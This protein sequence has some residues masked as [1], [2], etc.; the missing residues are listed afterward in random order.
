MLRLVA[1]LLLMMGI[2]DVWGQVDGIYYI[3]NYHDKDPHYS[4]ETVNTNYY[5]VPA[6]DG[7]EANIDINRWAWKDDAATPFVT[8][9]KTKRDNN[10][11]WVIKESD[12][13]G[14]YYLIH[15]LTGKYMTL[16]DGV[17]TNS[18]RRTFHMEETSNLGNDHLFNFTSYSDALT[19]YSIK[20]KTLSSG[21]R[22]VN[23]SKANQDKYYGT[24]TEEGG[25]YVAGLIGLYNKNATQDSGSKWFLE[26]ASVLP[27][28]TISDVN[29]TN[30]KV[31][32]TENNS[33]PTGYKVHYTFSAEGEPEDP[34][35][36]S[37]EMTNG[38]YQVTVAG[39]LKVVVERYDIVL[40]EV[41][42]KY[43]E[44]YSCANPVI[45]YS[46]ETGKVTIT[47][48][49]D[50]ASI[51]YTLDGT[52]PSASSTL[53]G[54][55]FSVADETTI[56]AIATKSGFADS[57]KASS[58]LLLN[59]TITLATTEYSYS[60]S[61]IEPAVSSVQDGGKTIGTDEYDVGYEYNT[62]AGTATVNITDK[63][64]G[65]YII[66]GSATFTI[67]PKALVITA[68]AKSKAYGDADPALTYTSEGLV[69]SD[70]ITGALN[71][72]VGEN[73][74]TYA[75][76]QNTL[77]AG[78]NY[79]ISYTGANLT[80]TPKA[81]TVTAKSKT[82]TYGDEPANDGVTYS[83]FVG[84][85]NASNL[86]GTITYAC[87]YEKYGDVGNY[88]ITPSGLTS[89]NYD[90][91][92]NNG[93]LI[94]NPKE[95]SLTW[96]ETTS[97]PY[98]GT[99]HCPTATATGMVNGDEIGVT[100]KGG[101][102]NA[103]NHTATAS[104]LMGDKANNYK[105]PDANTREFSI[106]KVGLTVT[107]NDN[108]ITYGNAPVGNGVTCEGFVNSETASVLGGTLDYDYSYTQYSDVGNTYTITPK[109]LTSNNYDI[110]FVAGTLTVAQKEV[111]ITW[112][113]TTSFVY[114]GSAHAPTATATGLVNSDAVTVVVTG[115]QINVGGYTATVSS[116]TGDKAGNYILL[117]ANTQSFTISPKSIG[118]GTLAEGY[119]LDFGE[120]NTIL[121]KDDIIGNA[122]MVSAD[123]SV[124]DDRDASAK[125]SERT[126]TG[127]GNYTGSFDVR[128]VVVSLTTDTDQEEWSATFA[129]EKADESDIGHALPEGISAFIISGIQGE[130][131]IPEPLNYIPE[132]VPV[133]LV[134]HKQINGF[135]VTRAESGDV[136]P[137]PITD[138][139]KTKNM[140][141]EVTE[142]TPGYDSGSESV[143]FETKQIYVL[144]KNEFVFNKAG[145]MKIGKVYLNPNHTAP[146]PGSAPARLKIA[147]NH[148]TGIQIIKDES[149][150][151]MQDDIWYTIDG[152]RLSGKPNAKGLYI[153]DGK[154]IVIK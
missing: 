14:D 148:T 68:E 78:S 51:Y 128:N 40:T 87:N 83:G 135:V 96:S 94:V 21:H 133:L 139:Q 29:Q 71:R 99:C 74:G 54:E 153:V 44:P 143:H 19:Y 30:N 39:T 82:I 118:E 114:D 144:Y 33:L 75:I 104:S 5:L 47:S 46:T 37:A 11:V 136:I 152:R 146:S 34:T 88:T 57:E 95:V 151:K 100:V 60:G 49:T 72:E 42:T 132:G 85:E 56:Q 18:N 112:G 91:T 110:S 76:N 122:L 7:G 129:A 79:S 131:V 55:P 109:G 65:N 26:T 134:A 92:Y 154:K 90:I 80:I 31:T 43:V 149:V 62:D 117:D 25:F 140:L 50:G 52:T 98:D 22:F 106:T 64:G 63:E 150:V 77:T 17:G 108:T 137:I 125:Y 38:E 66:Y 24:G 107:A 126:V 145:N 32:I 89:N 10:S 16:N 58:K 142:D 121:L 69:G 13:T 70:A 127:I 138:V 120:G 36:T 147:W 111:G 53:Y 4:P 35:A 2:G 6:Y 8:T 45:T 59:P 130:W 116:L 3:A 84:E 27:A 23:P 105:L 101:Q 41:A 81:L 15:L 115:A 141:E 124:S 113:E 97:F 119:T 102:T 123:Y 48:A 61:A 73:V 103:G 93:T 67:N 20:P 28:P 86:I 1:T 9:Y 12:T